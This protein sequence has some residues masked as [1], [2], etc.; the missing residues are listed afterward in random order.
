MTQRQIDSVKY[1]YEN[2]TFS[3]RVLNDLILLIEEEH[4]KIMSIK[5]L[6][7]FEKFII[8]NIEDISISKTKAYGSDYYYFNVLRKHT[9]AFTF[10]VLR[11]EEKLFDEENLFLLNESLRQEYRNFDYKVSEYERQYS[12]ILN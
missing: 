10:K 12:D 8:S 4:S 7:T 5:T 3:R 9:I 6:K 11:N 1:E 2:F